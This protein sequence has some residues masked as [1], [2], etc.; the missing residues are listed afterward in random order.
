M[1][2]HGLCLNDLQWN[3]RGHDHGAA[4][5]RDLGYT[6]VYL[7]YNTGLHISTNGRQLAEALEALL[8]QWPVPLE[9]FAL[10]AHS[11]GGLVARSACHYGALAAHAWPRHLGT[12]VFLGTP[13]HGAPMER[14]G[15][16]IDTLLEISPYTAPFARL[17]K[18]RSAG[19]TDLRYGNLA[20]EDWHG[21]DRFARGD[22]RRFVPLPDGVRCFAI[23]AT[24]AAKPRRVAAGRCPATGSSRSRARSA[25][26]TIRPSTSRIPK[27]R[28]WIAHDCGHL[29]LLDRPDGVP[30]DPA[31]ARCRASA[32]PAA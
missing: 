24:T 12:L 21:R 19:I 13:H 18:I 28:Q 9:E 7:H 2:A 17:G 3:R 10:V 30:A 15:N 29:D 6:P 20:D 16:W 5:A 32:P 8:A 14:G 23:G 25:G 1:L 31:V 11:M 27:S 26:T 22:R 4:L